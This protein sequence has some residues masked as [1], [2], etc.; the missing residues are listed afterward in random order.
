MYLASPPAGQ[1][2]DS[3]DGLKRNNETVKASFF[4]NVERGAEAK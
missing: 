3:K 4:F 2:Y 1:V